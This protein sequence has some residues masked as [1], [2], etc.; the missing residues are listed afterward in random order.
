[1]KQGMTPENKTQDGSILDFLSTTI[2]ILLCVEMLKVHASL[3]RHIF[4]ENTSRVTSVIFHGILPTRKR[5]ISLHNA[6]EN[7]EANEYE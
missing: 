7:T 3:S 6:I 4:Q 5:W 2:H 1:M